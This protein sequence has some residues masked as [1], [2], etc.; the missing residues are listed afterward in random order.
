MATGRTWMRVPETIRIVYQ[1]ELQP[2]VDGKDLI[3]YT[4]GQIGVSGAR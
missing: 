2:W 1:G 4:I 3:L